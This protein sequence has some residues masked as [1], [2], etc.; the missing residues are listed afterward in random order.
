MASGVFKLCAARSR[1]ASS[2]ISWPRG[3]E[4]RTGERR[5]R[6]RSRSTGAP[7]AASTCRRLL[8]PEALAGLGEGRGQGVAQRPGGLLGLLPDL[9]VADG[10]AEGA[11]RLLQRV[12]ELL[13]GL[14]DLAPVGRRGRLA[15]LGLLDLG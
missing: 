4:A 8:P 11:E 15:L 13:Q 7:A 5:G 1:S 12:P 3:R 2:A 9:R 6:A 10:V 14:V